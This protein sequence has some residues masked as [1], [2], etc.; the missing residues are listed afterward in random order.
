MSE[1]RLEV[2]NSS[3]TEI[4]TVADSKYLGWL[5]ILLRSLKV[6]HQDMRVVV[7]GVN[8]RDDEI[9]LI[10]DWNSRATVRGVSVDCS[11]ANFAATIANRRPYW[12]R[13]LMA[14]SRSNV[15][16]MDADMIIRAPI[17]PLLQ[18]LSDNQV[19]VV[20]RSG[21]ESQRVHA[22]LRVAAGLLYVGH[23]CRQFVDDWVATMESL[24]Q[25]EEIARDAWF[26]EQSCLHL[27]SQKHLHKCAAISP[28]LY[29]NSYPFSKEAFIWSA[30]AS[31]PGKDKILQIFRQ[32]L[33]RFTS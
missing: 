18:A 16:L 1:Q 19:G 22:C 21:W 24:E 9:N 10:S 13:E 7:I 8:L 31:G 11:A 17:D 3:E 4:M 20:F 23:M 27:T 12:L 32:E 14:S 25:I 15:L 29:L 6:F 28:E 2:L 33:E 30:H 26:W 5:E